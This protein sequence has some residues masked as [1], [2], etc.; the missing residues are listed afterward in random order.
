MNTPRCILAL[1]KWHV[2]KVLSQLPLFS[3]RL[4]WRKNSMK[5]DILIWR[6]ILRQDGYSNGT[7]RWC[8]AAEIAGIFTQEMRHPAPVPPRNAGRRP[9]PVHQPLLHRGRRDR[10]PGVRAYTPHHR[11]F[12]DPGRPVLGHPLPGHRSVAARGLDP[13]HPHLRLG[14]GVLSCRV[15][16]RP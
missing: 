6:Q 5:S 4:P 2:R 13:R 11:F 9:A 10:R 8:G 1:P 12:L 16:A 3:K 15:T 7:P 14:R